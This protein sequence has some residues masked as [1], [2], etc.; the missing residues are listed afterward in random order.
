MAR[1]KKRKKRTAYRGFFIF[2]KVQ[3]VLM[4]LLLSSVAYYYI[5]GYGKKVKELRE[6][7]MEIVAKSTYEDFKDD[8]TSVVYDINGNI[9]STL[10]GEK[11]VYYLRFEDIPA[12][13]VDA[14]V[15]IEDKKFFKH[16]GIDYKAILRA[17]WAMLKNG[18]VKQGGSTITQQLA[19]TIYLSNEKTWQRKVT[20]I[21]VAL[22]LEQKY[23]KNEILEF[24]LNNV[25][26][27]NGYYG[28]EAAS[29]GYFSKSVSELSLSEVAFI[30]A[31]PNS[32]NKYNPVSGM[33]ETLK[34]RD[35]ILGN[36]CKD[37]VIDS[38]TYKEAIAE[39]IVLKRPKKE[40]NNYAETYTYYCAI[41]KLMKQNGFE[42]KDKFASKDEKKRYKEAYRELY[43][44]CQ[45]SLY[46]NGYRI[47]TSIDLNMQKKLQEAIDKGLEENEEKNDEGVFEFQGAGV[48]IDNLTGKVVA[49]VGGRSQ[50]LEGYTLNRAYQSYRQPGSAIKPLIVY[51][52]WFER[53]MTPD[54]IVVDEKTE[55]GPSQSYYAGEMTV[56]EAIEQSKNTVAWNLFSELSPKVGLQYLINMGFSKIDKEDYRLTS[57]LG[58]FTNGVSPLEMASAY[59]TLCFDGFYREPTCIVKITDAN[60]NQILTGDTIE[61]KVYDTKA[62]RMMIDCMQG[63]LTEG[64]AK[65]KGLSRMPSCGKTGTTNDNKDGWFVG[66]SYYYTTSIWVGYDMPRQFEPLKGA[67]YPV[68]IWNDYMEKIHK[69]KQ[70]M[71]FR[72]YYQY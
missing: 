1:E 60:G 19:R 34:R 12:T 55:N 71:D 8:Q 67:T 5:G 47:Y 4:I 38:E 9:I 72:P 15:S 50:E 43:L 29:Q 42:F 41:Q 35:R 13:F 32:P 49:I 7:A 22:K 36:M 53:G 69:G 66:S 28:I 37:E 3:L 39:E 68:E 24:Y 45:E 14:I 65:D 16:K 18:E 56:R 26:F 61:E 27:A 51:T 6:E 23:T 54:S 30:C 57:A 52:P 63:V 59:A 31:I 17:A 10:V 20:E 21:F 70:A 58:G 64:T 25:Y 48:C 40:H 33:D 46:K 2:F 11:D 44:E 62:A